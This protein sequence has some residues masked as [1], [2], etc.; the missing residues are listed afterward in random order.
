MTGVIYQPIWKWKKIN[1]EMEEWSNER[2]NWKIAEMVRT[3]K[4]LNP[5]INFPDAIW[6]ELVSSAIY[7]LNGMGKSSVEG[8]SPY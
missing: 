7:I 4:Y 3:L 8:V 2:E 6:A 5:E 1:E